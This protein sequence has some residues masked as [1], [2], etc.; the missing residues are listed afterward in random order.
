MQTN[1]DFIVTKEEAEILNNFKKYVVVED[2]NGKIRL[3][4]R[5]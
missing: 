4:K 3:E 1:N 2:H 5:G